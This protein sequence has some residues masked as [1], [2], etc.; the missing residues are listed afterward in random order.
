MVDTPNL[1]SLSENVLIDNASICLDC[2]IPFEML[3]HCLKLLLLL[4]TN[5]S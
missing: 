2:A 3:G 4:N 5:P 1:Q